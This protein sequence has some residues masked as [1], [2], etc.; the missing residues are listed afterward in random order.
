MAILQLGGPV[1]IFANKFHSSAASS[2]GPTHDIYIDRKKM[3]KMMKMTLRYFKYIELANQ[4]TIETPSLRVI[5]CLLFEV[6]NCS[7][8]KDK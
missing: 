3:E 4:Q 1:L 5:K 6:L 7:V 8:G 2:L